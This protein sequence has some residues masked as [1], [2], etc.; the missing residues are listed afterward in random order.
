MEM[1][2]PRRFLDQRHCRYEPHILLVPQGE[3]LKMKS[4]EPFIQYT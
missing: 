3:L 2:E 1:P 4:S